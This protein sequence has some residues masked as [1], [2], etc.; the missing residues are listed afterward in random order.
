MSSGKSAGI[1]LKNDKKR[2]KHK[3]VQLENIFSVSIFCA[4]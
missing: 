4:T 3:E 2:H 1:R